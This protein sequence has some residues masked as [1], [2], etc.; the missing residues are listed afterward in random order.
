MNISTKTLVVTFFSVLFGLVQAQTKAPPTPVALINQLII[1]NTESVKIEQLASGLK[2]PWSLAFVGKDEILISE[3]HGGMRL[4]KNGALSKQ[5]IEGGP[6]SPLQISDSGILDIA[7]DPDF[8]SNRLIY[9][10]FVEGEKTANHT[11]IWKAR[12]V[13]NQLVEGR[14]IFRSKPDKAEPKHPGGR[15]LF[16]PDKS[17]LLT[18]GDGFNYKAAAQDL[19]SHLGKTLRLD[20]EGRAAAENPF[21][22]TPKALPE[23]WT[24]GHRNAQG[25]TRDITTGEIWL[26][27]HG[28]RGGDEV[29]LL[30]AGANYGWPLLT[31]G[32]DYDGSIISER[33]FA[34]GMQRASFI[35]VPSI[36]PSGL[37]VY[38]GEI[39]PDWNGKLLVG[40]LAAKSISRLRKGKDSDLLIEE[41]RLI[42]NLKK[43]IRDVR[44]GPDGLIYVLTDSADGELLRL[45]PN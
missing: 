39:F 43:R 32:V 45:R 38:R 14:V 35:W 20:K 37:A 3:K 6:P 7:L 42:G 4:W 30:V 41:E 1:P 15:M 12:L 5:F 11:A 36:A 34:P 23:I 18:I 9:I 31:H 19:G 16:L 25:L 40:A 8:N 13:D 24:Y 21:V 27:E 2:S 22:K 44:V 10:S 33:A 17:L 26:H 28:P 29:N